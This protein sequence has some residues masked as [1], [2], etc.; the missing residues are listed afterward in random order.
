MLQLL[1]DVNKVGDSRSRHFLVIRER[2]IA[3]YRPLT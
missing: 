1:T 3:R 2:N